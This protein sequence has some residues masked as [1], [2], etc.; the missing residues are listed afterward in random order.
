MFFILMMIF[1]AVIFF[2]PHGIPTFKLIFILNLLVLL[3]RTAHPCYF[4]LI[5]ADVIS[6]AHYIVLIL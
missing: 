5:M 4:A 1:I 6:Q 2:F 3:S